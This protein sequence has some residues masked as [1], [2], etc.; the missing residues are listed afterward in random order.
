[1]KRD[2][3]NNVYFF[4]LASL[5][6]VDRQRVANILSNRNAATFDLWDLMSQITL[7]NGINALTY[8]H[9]LVKV[10]TPSGKI[11]TPSVGHRG[12]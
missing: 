10:L 11:M 12:F 4:P 7:N 1:M 5:D 3:A 6:N 2:P 9:Q 8:F